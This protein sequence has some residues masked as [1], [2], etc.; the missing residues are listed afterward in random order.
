MKSLPSLLDLFAT[1]LDTERI[2]NYASCDC[3]RWRITANDKVIAVKCE[4]RRFQSELCK[5][6]LPW[7]NLCGIFEETHAAQHFCRPQMNPHS[8]SRSDSSGCGWQ[9]GNI[10]VD[11]LRG[12][13]MSKRR[14]HHSPLDY[15]NIN[16]SK[17]NGSPLPGKCFHYWLAMHLNATNSHTQSRGKQFELI[18]FRNL[19]GDQRASNNSTKTFY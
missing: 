5:P 4:Y 16:S 19:S 15:R 17:V 1:M 6:A 12:T 10:D 2:D 13:Q 14:E 9:H 7:R 18:A 11:N 8:R 3:C